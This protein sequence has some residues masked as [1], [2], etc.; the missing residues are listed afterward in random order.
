MPN[1]IIQGVSYGLFIALSVG[2]TIFAILKYSLSYG[3]K[4]G[5]SYIAG[6]SL[7][8]FLFV[9][10]ANL[11]A[12]FLAMANEHQ[13]I[14]GIGGS[15][16]LIAM[17]LYGFFKKLIVQ[18]SSNTI[19]EVNTGGLV[20]IGLS[21]FFMN[22]F[23]PGVII[24]WIAMSAFVSEESFSYK[25]TCFITA[26]IIILGFDVLK[27]LGANRVRRLL[28]PRNVIYLQR[29]SALC[30]LGVGIFIFIKFAFL[31]AIAQSHVH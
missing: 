3:H 10:I 29:I 12:N 21:G 8:D 15:L 4:A 22:T 25:S 27:V 14:I 13:K 11:A 6:V 17:G 31:N 1:A 30:L 28:T 2:P 24:T 5:F 19:A 26:L 9:A 16:L 18:R 23:N 7:S 20:K